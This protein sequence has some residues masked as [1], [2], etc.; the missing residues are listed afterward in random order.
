MSLHVVVMKFQTILQKAPIDYDTGP[1]GDQT[2][3]GIL[4]RGHK[5][6]SILTFTAVIIKKMANW[7]WQGPRMA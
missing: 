3:N 1:V 6:L 5:K 2:V 7:T 4:Y